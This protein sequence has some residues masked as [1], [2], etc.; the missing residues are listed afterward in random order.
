MLWSQPTLEAGLFEHNATWYVEAA[1]RM[2]ATSPATARPSDRLEH[3]LSDHHQ[4]DRDQL[5]QPG[6]LNPAAQEDIQNGLID[7]RVINLLA[8]LTQKYSLLIQRLRSDHQP[9]DRFRQRLE[10][11]LRTGHGH[12]RGK[13]RPLHSTVGRQPAP[14]RSCCWPP[15]PT[16]SKPTRLIYGWDVDGSGP[17]FALPDHTTTSTPAWPRVHFPDFF[18]VGSF[19]SNQGGSLW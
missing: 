3:L 8:I 5:G 1:V 13:R 6:V 15:C 17:A 10:P 19:Q 9:D 7:Q 16:G 2:P 12:R 14:R 18:G 11:L 4:R